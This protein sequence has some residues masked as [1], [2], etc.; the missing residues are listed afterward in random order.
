MNWND[1]GSTSFCVVSFPGFAS[2]GILLVSMLLDVINLQRPGL[3][4]NTPSQIQP[5]GA[6]NKGDKS[7]IE[8]FRSEHRGHVGEAVRVL[9]TI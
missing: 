6:I 9:S 1:A 5:P 4:Q 3:H 7:R 2:P 8:E